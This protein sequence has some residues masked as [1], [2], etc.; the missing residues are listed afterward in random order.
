[1]L[2]WPLALLVVDLYTLKL[3]GARTSRCPRPQAYSRLGCSRGAQGSRRQGATARNL[4]IASVRGDE[5]RLDVVR[6]F[7]RRIVAL[8]HAR[9]A[10]RDSGAVVGL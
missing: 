3:L 9:V 1:M 2:P 6:D 7:N 10:R 8:F 4:V 5:L